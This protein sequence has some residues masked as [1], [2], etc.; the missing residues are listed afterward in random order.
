MRRNIITGFGRLEIDQ[1]VEPVVP[2]ERSIVQADAAMA[3][4]ENGSTMPQDAEIPQPVDQRRLNL[5]G[6]LLKS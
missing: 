3:A 1:A 5:I 4:V 6:M 2:E